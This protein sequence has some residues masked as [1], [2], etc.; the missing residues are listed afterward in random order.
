MHELS[1]L[2]KNVR[3]QRHSLADAK[4]AI[5]YWRK[6]IE[7]LPSEPAPEA[8]SSYLLYGPEDPGAAEPTEWDYVELAE[9]CQSADASMKTVDE[10]LRC[11]ALQFPETNG[12]GTGW[13]LVTELI[14]GLRKISDLLAI[15]AKLL[16]R[17][18]EADGSVREL[19]KLYRMG[20]LICNGEGLI[21]C[22]LVGSGIRGRAL[23]QLAVVI[24]SKHLSSTV[25]RLARDRLL[26]AVRREDGLVQ[27]CRVELIQFGIP[28]IDRVPET[29]NCETLVDYL[30]DQLYETSLIS[31]FD[32]THEKVSQSI[33]DE[34]QLLRKEQLHQLLSG[35][36][37]AFD[38]GDTIRMLV[39]STSR[40]IS[41]LEFVMRS[42]NSRWR[43]RL[44]NMVSKRHRAKPS[45]DAI[46]IWP[47]SLLP[48]F[49]F[50]LFG[51]D[52]AAEAARRE[53]SC[54]ADGEYPPAWRPLS[55]SDLGV[56]NRKLRL[57]A[58]PVGKILAAQQIAFDASSC[59]F[60]HFRSLQTV[61]RTLSRKV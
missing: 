59:C 26:Q 15:R 3:Y 57:V 32:D 1:S 52:D 24:Q 13:E 23:K 42:P 28:T 5:A 31:D 38:R 60:E 20:E 25:G 39:Q 14:S 43:H 47:E 19:L 53:F 50:E 49:P 34:R 9:W 4:N 36:P 12:F 33:R 30:V 17:N 21:V 35:H 8:A 44:R 37:K 29:S 55:P 58:N 48:G 7:L 11:D 22:Y 10:G 2:P 18:G 40:Y 41:W 61:V 51:E 16:E 54:S 27:A 45:S 46:G 56:R 6:A